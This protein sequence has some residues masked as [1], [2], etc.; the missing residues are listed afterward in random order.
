ME[1]FDLVAGDWKPERHC[2]IGIA[3]V[4]RNKGVGRVVVTSEKQDTLGKIAVPVI[5]EKVRTA[6]KL[7]T[8]SPDA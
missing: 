4:D 1:L 7:E 2:L 6:A 8:T 3:D 5:K